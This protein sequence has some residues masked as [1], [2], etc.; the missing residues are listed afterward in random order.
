MVADSGALNLRAKEIGKLLHEARIVREL[1]SESCAEAIGVTKERYEEYE[2]GERAPSLPEWECLAY[3]LKI[4]IKEFW[5]P[6]STTRGEEGAPTA[7]MSQ[8]IYL[9]QRMIGAKL[10]EARVSKGL[11][12]SELANSIGFKESD[13]IAYELGEKPIPIPKLEILSETLNHSIKEFLDQHGP[14]G[15]WEK[16]KQ[17]VKDFEK[18]PLELQEFVSKPINEPYL[19][20]AVRLSEISVDRLRAVAEGL[21]EITY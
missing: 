2:Q 14:V 18:L 13:I 15:E 11:S 8:L 19:E 5:Q 16:H 12:F 1:P 4:S 3:I 10:R 7:D 9:R 20:L 17:A 21:L 6:P